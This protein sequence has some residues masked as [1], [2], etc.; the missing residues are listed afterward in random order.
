MWNKKHNKIIIYALVLVIVVLL[1]R[2]AKEFYLQTCLMAQNDPSN[3]L[4][5]IRTEKIFYLSPS[6]S[7]GTLNV[8]VPPKIAQ[9]G[10]KIGIFWSKYP[11]EVENNFFFC[12]V[13]EILGQFNY[14]PSFKFFRLMVR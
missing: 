2:D 4:Y 8:T 12:I 5:K 6:W 1:F 10:P 9:N 11:L 14:I 7:I 13:L 3:L